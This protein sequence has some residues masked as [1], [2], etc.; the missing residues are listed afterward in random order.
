MEVASAT[1]SE[2]P[3]RRPLVINEA[4]RL[5]ALHAYDVLDTPPEPA[6]DDLAKLAAQI[7]A[8]PS[9]FISLVDEHRQMVQG[10]DGFRAAGNLARNVL[11]CTCSSPERTAGCP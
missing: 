9:A 1:L 5:A 3:S 7:C 8:A 10:T 6:F 4:R 11:L 2:A